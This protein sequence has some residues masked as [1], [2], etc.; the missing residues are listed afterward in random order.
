MWPKFWPF[1]EIQPRDK[2]RMLIAVSYSS[3]INN[4]RLRILPHHFFLSVYIILPIFLNYVSTSLGWVALP[5]SRSSL[6]Y[7]SWL[8]PDTKVA[9]TTNPENH[10]INEGAAGASETDFAKVWITSF[11]SFDGGA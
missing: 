10:G 6:P 2:W 5:G 4:T 8:A 1:A 11:G 9:M 3:I 7:P